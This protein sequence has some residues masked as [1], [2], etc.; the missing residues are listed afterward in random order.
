MESLEEGPKMS[1]EEEGQKIVREIRSV[2]V[3]PMVVKT[4]IELDLFEIMA[5][6]PGARFSSCDL[7]SN[8]PSQTPQTPY[9]LERILRFL[10]TQS[11]LESTI[12]TDEHGNSKSL[13]SMTPVSNHFVR[14]QDGS[15]SGS[16]LLLIYDKVLLDCWHHLK[17]VV[18]DGGIPFNKAH[19]VNAFEYQAKDKRF[20]QVFNKAMYDNTRIVM[21]SILEKYKGFEGVKELVDVGGGLGASIELII[22]KYPNI[23]GINFD[24]PHVIK[25]ATPSPGVEHVGGDMFERVPKGDVIFM[26][27]ILHDWGDDY[28]IKLLKNC[29]E[30]LPEDGKVVVVE[31]VIPDPEY[32]PTNAADYASAK[33]AVSGDMIMLIANPG[34]K[35]RTG[36]E[37]DALA[38]EGGFTSTKIVCEGSTFSIMEFYKNV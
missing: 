7:A 22:S 11:I 38:K 29:W 12:E 24:L 28:C 5:K 10:A 37:F 20:N 30:A 3:L 27:W 9:L 33:A 13:Y 16:L 17:Y 19:G 6:T 23:K 1:N 18:T 35:E 4:A 21:K 2:I 15:S 25:D 8:L 36:K 31:G 26:K 32:Q 14:D 34:G